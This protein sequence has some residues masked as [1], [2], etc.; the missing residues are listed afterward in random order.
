M[1]RCKNINIYALLCNEYI[2][3]QEVLCEIKAT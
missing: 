1:L 3:Q 2:Y